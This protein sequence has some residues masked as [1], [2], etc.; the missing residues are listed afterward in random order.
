MTVLMS[1]RSIA[2]DVRRGFPCAARDLR[3]A[4]VHGAYV[5]RPYRDNP[6]P[7]IAEF[8]FGAWMVANLTLKDRP[9]ANSP[10][11]FPLAWDNVFTR[12]RRWVMSWRHISAGSIV[13]QRC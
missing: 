12:V 3:G 6:P 11:D 9:E 2:M 8:H 7:H 13:V 10:R 1:S 4:A 5:V